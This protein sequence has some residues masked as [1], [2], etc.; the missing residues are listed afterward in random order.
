MCTKC[1]ISMPT[2]CKGQVCID[3]ADANTNDDAN[4]NDHW[5]SM[6]VQGSLVD[7]QNEPKI[8]KPKYLLF[9]NWLSGTIQCISI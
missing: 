2:L 9:S 4:V 5:Q 6:T 3:D 8:A 7:K 1:K